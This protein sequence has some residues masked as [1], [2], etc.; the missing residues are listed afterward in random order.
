[1]TWGGRGPREAPA[2]PM[3]RTTGVPVRQLFEVLDLDVVVDLGDPGRCPGGCD[4]LV[5]LGPGAHDSGQGY[6]PGGGRDRQA[7]GVQPGAARE[8][9][10]D[11]VRDVAPVGG[12]DQ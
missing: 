4:G 11:V 3:P 10:A 12:G 5:V 9:A 1:M 8:R 2:R 7:A 6:R